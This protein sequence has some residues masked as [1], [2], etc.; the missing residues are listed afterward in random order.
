M[1]KDG[2]WVPERSYSPGVL[3]AAE[4]AGLALSFPGTCPYCSSPTRA[5]FHNGPCPRVKAI[6]YHPN[7][8]VKR[9]EFHDGTVRS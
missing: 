9:V 5:T 7:G 4:V 2:D 3:V 1:S 6:E 8:A